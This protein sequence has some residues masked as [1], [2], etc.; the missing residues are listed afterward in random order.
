HR[1]GFSAITGSRAAPGEPTRVRQTSNALRGALAVQRASFSDLLS[2]RHPRADGADP[3]ARHRRGASRGV[4]ESGP[5]ALT[6]L[7][8]TAS[9][10]VAR[11]AGYAKRRPAQ[12][13]TRYRRPRQ[14]RG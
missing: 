11:A 7:L 5:A 8:V 4:G 13:G 12:D 3:G 10:R 2:R 1:T 9:G 14:P 6:R